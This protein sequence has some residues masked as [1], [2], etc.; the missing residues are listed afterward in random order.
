MT[1]PN[2]LKT[3]VGGDHYKK[4][5]I[6][7]LKFAE[8]IKLSPIIFCI[9]KYLC[10]YKDKNGIEDLKKADHC[11]DIFLECGKECKAVDH[12]SSIESEFIN[13]FEGEQKIA[14]I[15]VLILQCDKSYARFLKR[16]IQSL[17][18]ELENE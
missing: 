1:I 17:I 3:Q 2:S 15:E 4:Y 10:R 11:I 14:I 16:T 12:S 18:K 6:Q 5:K 13:Q 8:D 9:F 7:P